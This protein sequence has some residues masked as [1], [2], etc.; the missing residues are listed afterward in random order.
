[1]FGLFSSRD[2]V[3]AR[4]PNYDDRLAAHERLLIKGM[5]LDIRGDVA[6]S[7][8]RNKFYR[9]IPGI[10]SS[11]YDQLVATGYYDRRPDQV[12]GAYTALAVALFGL[13]GI[14]FF[15]FITVLA[16]VSSTAICL[17]VALAV[18]GVAFLIAARGMPVRT[19]KGAEVRARLAAFKRYL[20]NIQQYVD[21]KAA[22]DQ[23]DRY[24]PYAI[25]FGLDR[26]WIQK[27]AAIDTP[28][29]GWYIPLYM[30][31]RSFGGAGGLGGSGVDIGGAAKAG[32][33]VQG[34]D[35]GLTAGL[36]GMNAGLTAM[37]A[38]T[39]STFSSQPS[40][41][42]GGF[43]GGGGGGGGGSGGGGGGFG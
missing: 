5:G 26:A 30:P 36:A 12:R 17:S 10:Q 23:F 34:L 15:L 8:I 20:E 28:S 40:S 18:A 1:L 7:S 22:T 31:G 14:L 42:G 9:S 11:L 37:F 43:S 25:A 21:L 27:F 35:R 19:R 16:D 32:P 29:P 38:A 39:A 3:F 6:L 24:L 41:S 4:G 13:A 2:W 33:S